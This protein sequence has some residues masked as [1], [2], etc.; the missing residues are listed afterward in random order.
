VIRRRLALGSLLIASALAG[1]TA[2]RA[3]DEDDAAR[4]ARKAAALASNEEGVK[5]AE[6]GELEGALAKFAE[7]LAQ[8]PDDATIRSNAAKV[9][10][11]VAKKRYDARKFEDAAKE[12]HRAAELDPEQL[13]YL[14]DEGVSLVQAGADRDAVPV[15][16]RVLAKKEDRPTTL[17]ALGQALYRIGRNKD[18]IAR[19]ERALV[20][21][22]DDAGLKEALAK[23]KKEETVEGDL[24]ED[25][26]APHFTIKFDGRGDPRIGRIVG[27]ALEDAYRDVGYD[28]GRFPRGEVAVVV[29]PKQAF[30]AVT[31]THGWVA[32][33]YDGK[34]RVPAEGIDAAVPAELKRV[35]THEYTHALVRSIAGANVPAWLHEGIAQL[36]EGRTRADARATLKGKELPTLDDLAGTFLSDSDPERVRV[37]YASAY[38]FVAT[39]ASRRGKAS[40]AELLDRMGKGEKL[41]EA[42]KA[43]FGA[44]TRGLFDEWRSSAADR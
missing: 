38:D 34:I 28:L 6:K 44:D 42:A 4:A 1:A 24:F 43:I 29:Y 10:A 16:E 19:W 2:V 3:G 11:A 23:A 32:A 31:G 39:L 36:E 35:L 12:F 27:Q 26:G 37:R 8:D 40:F 22:P 18:A 13:D 14:H 7:A 21:S 17:I 5:L 30:R 33:L 25:L 9:H 20:L 15:L 41:D